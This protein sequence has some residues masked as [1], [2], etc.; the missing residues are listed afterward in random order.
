LVVQRDDRDATHARTTGIRVAKPRRR[1][2]CVN[3]RTRLRRLTKRDCGPNCRLV[4]KPP[5]P[6]IPVVPLKK[7]TFPVGLRPSDPRRLRTRR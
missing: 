4:L 1:R 2:A 3:R 7:R 5:L 6:V